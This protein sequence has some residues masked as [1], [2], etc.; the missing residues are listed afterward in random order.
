MFFRSVE[1]T[2]VCVLCAHVH[3]RTHNATQNHQYSRSL[4]NPKLLKYNIIIQFQPPGQLFLMF[5]EYLC[6]FL[7]KTVIKS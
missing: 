1:H 5:T 3:A 7:G 4:L 6:I 2:S